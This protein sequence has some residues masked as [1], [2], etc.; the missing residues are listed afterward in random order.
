MF[1]PR[2]LA[3]AGEFKTS[4]QVFDER[5]AEIQARTQAKLDE[6]LQTVAETEQVAAAT[7]DQ[8][9]SQGKQLEHID[10]TLHE[11]DQELGR[12]RHIISGA[13]CT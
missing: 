10:K 8:L 1:M 13:C 2:P 5:K 11:T 3:P 4:E 7:T 12:T 6:A 9:Y